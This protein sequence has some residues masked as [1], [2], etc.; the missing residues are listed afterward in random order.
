[1]VHSFQHGLLK[2][3]ET[4]VIWYQQFYASTNF[5]TECAIFCGLWD[6]FSFPSQC[7]SILTDSIYQNF[8][9]GSYLL[10]E[11]FPWIFFFKNLNQVLLQPRI[12]CLGTSGPMYLLKFFSFLGQTWSKISRF[13][14][15]NLRRFKGN[16]PRKIWSIFTDPLLS[17]F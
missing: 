4:I 14:S 10:W 1:M 16:F 6:I 15:S 13:F 2:C 11:H 8:E 5:V 12:F 3:P 17:E 9:K 7:V